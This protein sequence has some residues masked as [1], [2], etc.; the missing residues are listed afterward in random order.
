[1]ILKVNDKMDKIVEVKC[2]ICGQ[3]FDD[4][5][6][7]A[8]FINFNF[9]MGE[10]SLCPNEQIRFDICQDCFVDKFPEIFDREEDV[11][12]DNNNIFEN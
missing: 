6:E 7:I 1:M 2:D 3:I 10:K 4:P 8:E 11:D 9:T 5:D 12:D